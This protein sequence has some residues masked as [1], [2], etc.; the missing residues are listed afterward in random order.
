LE[1]GEG[2]GKAVAEGTIVAAIGV[3]WGGGGV[4]AWQAARRVNPDSRKRVFKF[5]V[6]PNI[7]PSL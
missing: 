2:P 1:V 6:L 4:T 3:G 5:I 7:Y